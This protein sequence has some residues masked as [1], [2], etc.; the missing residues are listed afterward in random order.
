MYKISQ[1]VKQEFLFILY[2]AVSFC[3]IFVVRSLFM[4]YSLSRIDIF[5]FVVLKKFVIVNKKKVQGK[6]IS[7]HEIMNCKFMRSLSLYRCTFLLRKKVMISRNYYNF[8]K[9]NVM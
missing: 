5:F 8:I 3:I 9:I 2:I 1:T 6:I 7:S 4:L